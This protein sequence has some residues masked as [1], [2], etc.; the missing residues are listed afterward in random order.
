MRKHRV[1]DGGGWLIGVLWGVLLVASTG[2]FADRLQLREDHPEVYV[3]KRGDTLWDIS[4][5]FLRD[6]WRWPEI[7]SY[8]PQVQNPHLIYP[9]DRLRLVFVDGEPKLVRDG[10]P[11]R[12]GPQVRVQPLSA[13]VP[14][15]PMEHLRAFLTAD[16]IVSTSD[17]DSAPYVLA[18]EEGRL[19]LG[20]GDHL[21]ARGVEDAAPGTYGVYRPGRVFRDPVSGDKLGIEARFIGAGE[22]GV[23]DGDIAALSL[24]DTAREVRVGDRLLPIEPETLLPVF[25][26]QP[27]PEVTEAHLIAVVGG[28]NHIG[29]YDVVVINRGGQHGVAPGHVVA[30]Y[31]QGAK[32]RD[33]EAREWVRLPDERAGLVMLF[34]VHEAMSYGLVMHAQRPMQVMDRVRHP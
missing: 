1:V 7:W 18:G 21:Y 30:V 3:V 33:A 34:D 5:T 2:A 6:P 32:V 25:S 13:A 16:R 12:L 11:E 9:G 26:P 20:S 14:A 17:L 22:L 28:M 19:I 24:D 29:Q 31:R 4:E 8:N 23:A 15:I 27:A 10:G